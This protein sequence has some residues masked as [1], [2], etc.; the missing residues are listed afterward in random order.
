MPMPA[1]RLVA[2]FEL[3]KPVTWFPPMWA[4]VCGVVSAGQVDVARWPLIVIGV[5]LAGPLVCGASQAANDWFDR[6]VDA[7]NE[8]GRPIPSGRL[9]RRTGLYVA[10]AWTLLALGVATRLGAWGFCATAAG[11]VLA[12]AY[13]A[14]PL[15][16]KAHGWL[17][18]SAAAICYEALPWVM[19]AVIASGTAPD[20]HVLLIAALYSVGA[21]GI[22]TLN[23]FRSVRGDRLMGVS[24]L[25]VQ[26]GEDAAPFACFVMALA[27]AV[28][29][30]LLFYWGH[31]VLAVIVT[32][33]W[34]GQLGLMDPFLEQP[35]AR[36]RWYNTTGVPLYGV[37]MLVAAL[38]LRPVLFG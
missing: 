31:A 22:M 37:G 20:A 36:A 5:L 3:L 9:P 38:A 34:L 6:D 25:P 27:Q 23:D 33:L 28:V 35:H 15:R 18:N 29:I 32:A 8:P 24:S 17:G 13:S 30:G 16:L 11:V 7:I 26:M 2:V 14:P 10:V 19:G 12:W 1:S 4:F 21:H